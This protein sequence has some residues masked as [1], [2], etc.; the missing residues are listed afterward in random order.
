MVNHFTMRK[1]IQ[2]A[3]TKFHLIFMLPVVGY[4]FVRWTFEK[5][6]YYIF[7][8]AGILLFMLLE[9]IY[10]LVE[11][12]P[13]I[14]L[15]CIRYLEFCCGGVWMLWSE[16]PEISILNFT[17]LNIFNVEFFL[18]LKF[19]NRN[20]RK[21]FLISVLIPLE[22]GCLVSYYLKN[23]SM[24]VFSLNVINCLIYVFFIAFLTKIF[25]E[26]CQIYIEKTEE[27]NRVI[28]EVKKTNK[29]LEGHQKDMQNANLQLF[30]R[31][32]ELEK[33][34]EEIRNTNAMMNLQIQIIRNISA[35]LSFEQLMRV[36]TNLILEGMDVDL[37][38]ISIYAKK[39]GN[40]EV[41]YQ[42]SSRYGKNFD[43]SVEQA[44]REDG[45]SELIT[46][47]QVYVDNF[48]RNE[49]YS[50]FSDAMMGSLIIYPIICDEERAGYLVVGHPKHRF[51]GSSME[52]FFGAVTDE[53]TIALKNIFLYEQMKHLAIHDPLTGLYNRGK[54]MELFS[55]EVNNAMSNH[56]SLSVVMFD[57]DYFKKI[58]DH[59]GHLVGDK[60]IKH[61]ADMGKKIASEHGGYIGRYGG[62]E[63]VMIFPDCSEEMVC[64]RIR[65]LHYLVQNS[66]FEDGEVKVYISSGITVFPSTCQKPN[67]ILKYAD[68]AMYYSK[69]N[70]RNRMTVDSPFVRDA[71]ELN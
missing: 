6:V 63:F 54:L 57:I 27:Q 71:L 24:E 5:D 49:K 4:L 45:F 22:I 68:M 16:H 3:F 59:Y 58:N 40:E 26:G 29:I 70:G 2:Y 67:D 38:A 33:A 65:K 20:A 46:E 56:K 25:T 36:I 43:E 42:V 53:I 28:R 32:Q 11:R 35:S 60:I 30:Q 48:V 7:F 21:A 34:N 55:Q 47:N 62:E 51:F 15:C 10:F 12:L 19:E 64:Q 69:Q 23:D 66:V 8:I 52:E 14:Y 1:K 31:K 13:I 61:V 18:C 41:M 39:L 50:W 9:N 44:F 17:L 37:C